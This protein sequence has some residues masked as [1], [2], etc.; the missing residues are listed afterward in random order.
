MCNLLKALNSADL[1][2]AKNNIFLWRFDAMAIRLDDLSEQQRYWFNR[3][4][5][6]RGAF[7]QNEVA[8]ITLW[9]SSFNSSGLG[10]ISAPDMALLEVKARHEARPLLKIGLAGHQ[11]PDSDPS[12]ESNTSSIS[13][14]SF[15]SD[16]ELGPQAGSPIALP[17]RSYRLV[18][19]LWSSI[20]S[21]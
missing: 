1:F 13:N 21:K 18:G 16:A 5:K 17:P 4:L 3:D 14:G 11:R 10:Q 20:S 12:L 2:G 6:V 8:C 19:H 15:A 7:D 9:I